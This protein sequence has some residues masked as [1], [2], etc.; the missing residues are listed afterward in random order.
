LRRRAGEGEG[1]HRD[2]KAPRLK[3]RKFNRKELKERKDGDF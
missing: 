3:K 1:N 2:T